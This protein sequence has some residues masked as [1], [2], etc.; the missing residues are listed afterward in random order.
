MNQKG[1]SSHILIVAL[2][3]MVIFFLAGCDYLPFADTGPD[4][5]SSTSALFV[6]DFSGEQNCGWA[7]YNQGGAVTA[8]E[9]GVLKISTS[10]PGEIWWTNPGGSF[11]DVVI[12]VE[13]KQVSGPDDNAYGI[14]CRYQDEN[15][16]Y[17]FLISG[18]GYYAIGKYQGA[19]DRVFYL[20]ENEQFLESERINQGL[21]VNQIQAACVGNQLSLM[22]NGEALLSVVDTSF[23]SGDVGL[24]ASALQQGT[25]TVE[26]DDIR[27]TSP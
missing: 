16:F 15:N 14:I 27:V 19:E 12:D 11:D 21:A 23:R 7:E 6:D 3:L 1:I 18:D 22:V 20:T 24:T 8:I 5:C 10:S 4:D 17:L 13:A 9:D 25:V 2:L 26:F